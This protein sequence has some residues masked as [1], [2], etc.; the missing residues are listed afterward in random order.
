MSMQ[1]SIIDRGGDLLT[2]LQQRFARFAGEDHRI[3]PS[4]LQ[5]AL[6]IRDPDYASKIFRIF[7]RDGSGTVSC[8]EF[9]AAIELLIAADPSVR[10][11]F[12]FQLHDD[13]RDGLI[14]RDELRTIFHASL[15]ENQLRFA[16]DDIEALIEA[17]FEATDRNA[18]GRVA[19][20]EFKA[21]VE[22][23]PHIYRQMTLSAV[24]W[25]QPPTASATRPNAGSTLAEPLR[26]TGHYLQ[27]NW[28]QLLFLVLYASVNIWLFQRAMQ[29]YASVGANGYIQLA[30]GCG[31]CLNF[32][33]ALILIP[34]LRQNLTWL[35]RTVGNH[36]LPLDASTAFHRLVGHVMF[37]LSVVHAGAHGLNYTMLTAPLTDTLLGTQA[38]LTGLALLI[39]FIVMWIC[40]LDQVRRR[41]YFELFYITHWGFVTWFALAVF[42]GPVFWQWV[43]LPLIGYGV[44]RLLRYCKVVEPTHVSHVDLLPSNVT[45]LQ[46]SRPAAFQYRA[47][48]YLFICLPAISRFE[49][50]PFTLTSCPE[51]PDYLSLHVRS[52]GNWTRALYRFFAAAETP[53]P[54]PA[55]VD[56]PYGAPAEHIFASRYAVLIGAGIGVTP[57]ASILKSLLYRYRA[58]A[59]HTM[60]LRKVHFYWLNKSQD[61]F[62]WF[63]HMLAELE[64]ADRDHLLD[65][66]IYMTGGQANMKSSTLNIAMELLRQKTRTD[67]VT[68][69]QARTHMGRPDWDDIFT[70]IADA[71]TP[72]KP[73]VFFCGPP[74]LGKTLKTLCTRHNFRFRKENF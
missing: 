68:G 39:V 66:N 15:N 47:G 70:T 19:F 38:G 11:H 28:N 52:V 2:D 13:D 12:V 26:H 20:D 59:T 44:E 40:A 5:A 14:S 64:Q 29:H 21:T 60:A 53:F 48:Q 41:G 4:E 46:L 24:P 72:D 49:W 56:G 27:N 31:A 69:L 34:M 63:T 58:G 3:D 51:E 67:L 71:Y 25:L 50:H 65:I 62:E 45:H 61:S 7:D 74:G 9:L 17:L 16:P 42:H 6:D 8:Q 37:A 36:Y 35:R 57:F 32:N 23:H 1:Q 18:D 43:T 55:H 22:A 54:I 10:L 33:G 73:D 30:R